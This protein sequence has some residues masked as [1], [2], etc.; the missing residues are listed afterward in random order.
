[1]PEVSEGKMLRK[2]F[3][4]FTKANTFIIITLAK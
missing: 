1:M 4:R 3:A 2:D